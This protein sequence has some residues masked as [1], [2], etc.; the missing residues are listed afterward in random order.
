MPFMGSSC[1]PGHFAGAAYGCPQPGVLTPGN[2][3]NECVLAIS[4]ARKYAFK[5]QTQKGMV[6]IR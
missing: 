6:K 5:S 2:P 3:G 1:P 4:G